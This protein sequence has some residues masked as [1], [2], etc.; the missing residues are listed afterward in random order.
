MREDKFDL[1]GEAKVCRNRPVRA[2]DAISAI[3]VCS[4]DNLKVCR[5]GWSLTVEK[6]ES[7]VIVPPEAEEWE[8]PGKL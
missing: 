7:V 1:T 6:P 5:V 3:G 8:K 2:I 4:R